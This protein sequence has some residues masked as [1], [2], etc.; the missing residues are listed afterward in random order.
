[1]K[2][3]LVVGTLFFFF[4]AIAQEQKPFVAPKLVV[5]IVVDQMRFDYLTRFW[6]RYSDHGFRRMVNQGFNAKNHHFNYIP[7]VTG[8]GHASV[9]TGATPAV[10][11]I[12]GNNWYDK[13]AKEIVYCAGDTAY[14]AL[15]T[16]NK[17]GMAPTRMLTTTITDQLRIHY[18]FKSKVI[19]VSVKDR[20]AVLPGGHTANAAYWYEGGSTGDWISSTYYMDE[21][22]KWVQKYNKSKAVERYK[23][24]WE[25]LEPLNTY[26]ES[27]SDQNA[28]EGLSKGEEHSGFPHHLDKL[29]DQN[30]AFSSLSATPFG[31]SILTDFALEALE[32]EELGTDEIPDFLAI[33]YSS[34]DY[35][36]HKYGVN[37]VEVQDT[38]MRL[39]LEIARLLNKLDQTVGE[40]EYLVFLTSDHGAVHVP[41][42]LS[43][44]KTP[45]GYINSKELMEA[46]NQSIEKRFG[47]TDILENLSSNELFLNHEIID[48]LGLD[49]RAVREQIADMVLTLPLV[50]Q[51]FTAHDIERLG[52]AT[53][54]KELVRNGHNPKRSGDVIF[55]IQPAYISYGKT[56]STHGSPHIYDTHVPLLFFGTGIPEGEST[57]ERTEI[58]D[59]AP[60]LAVLLGIGMPN[61]TTGTPIED[62]LED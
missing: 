8:P 24:V 57:A 23:T 39:D 20:G 44:H 29:W 9:Y 28:Y 25:T 61:G 14:P 41:S 46:L 49:L 26:T 17:N 13:S 21:L 50:E 36:G 22:P 35:V 55:T 18:Q 10:H 27:G 4:H 11:G 51:V 42:F 34:T 53:G 32:A 15:G 40:G 7:T 2:K 37:S 52:Y 47:R 30:G 54:M 1:M 6:D 56:G 38:Y 33:S 59:I 16:E 60:T 45:S 62:L 31:N 5:G 12:L 19:A 48:E 58:P 43:D 3:F